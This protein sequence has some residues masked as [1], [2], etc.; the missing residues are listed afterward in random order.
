MF[1]PFRSFLVCLTAV[2]SLLGCGASETLGGD[3]GEGGHGGAP[4]PQPLSTPLSIFEYDPFATPP[5]LYV[6]IQGARVCELDSDNCVTSDTDGNAVIDLPARQETGF[7][8]EKEGYGSWLYANVTDENFF[9][10]GDRPYTIALMS[11]EQLAV[12]ANDLQTPYPWQGGVALFQRWYPTVGVKFVPVGP[13]ADLVGPAFYLDVAAMTYR[14]ELNATT[15]GLETGEMPL[16][17][18]GFVEV[19]PGVHQFELT[20]DMEGCYVTSW[21]WPGDAPNRFRI[22]VREGY[23]TYGSIRCEDSY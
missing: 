15:S 12:I 20:G 13:T 6:P 19:E 9:Q 8:I 1:P 2:A 21:G 10:Y 17:Q 22:P 23:R 7:T 5:R 11:N 4:D 3:G 16:G 14:L 18:G